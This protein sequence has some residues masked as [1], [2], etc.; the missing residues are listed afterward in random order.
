[1]DLGNAPATQSLIDQSG[2][3]FAALMLAWCLRV[4]VVDF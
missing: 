4:L 2:F 1:L 3:L